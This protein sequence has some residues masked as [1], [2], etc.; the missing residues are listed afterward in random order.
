MPE[1]RLRYWNAY[2]LFYEKA[3]LS[4]PA[5]V[6]DLI[7]GSIPRTVSGRYWTGIVLR[8]T[9]YVFIVVSFV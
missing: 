8:I 3:D 7:P 1:S 6:D 2:L 9:L 5:A 4:L